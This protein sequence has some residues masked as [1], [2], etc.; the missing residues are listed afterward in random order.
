MMNEIKIEKGSSFPNDQAQGWM[1]KVNKGENYKNWGEQLQ[2]S[3]YHEH[4]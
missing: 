2:H 1:G 4:M 3:T